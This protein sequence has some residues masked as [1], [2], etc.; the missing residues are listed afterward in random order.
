MIRAFIH[1]HLRCVKY[2]IYEI[3]FEYLLFMYHTIH[4]HGIIFVDRWVSSDF[5]RNRR[6]RLHR[7]GCTVG[8]YIPSAVGEMRC[9]SY[10]D[11]IVLFLF[12][13]I[14]GNTYL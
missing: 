13:Q 2:L 1:K 6:T 5:R 10:I 14:V 7:Q 3:L 11:Q 8:R 12:D 9:V 4:I